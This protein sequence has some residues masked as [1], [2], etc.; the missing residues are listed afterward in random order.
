MINKEQAMNK[1]NHIEPTYSELLGV[2]LTK[3]DKDALTAIAHEKGISPTLL[4]RLVLMKYIKSEDHS[5]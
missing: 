5:L 3:Y 4:A 2:R 1:L